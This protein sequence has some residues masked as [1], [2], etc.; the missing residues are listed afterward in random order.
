MTIEFGEKRKIH[1]RG[2]LDKLEEEKSQENKAISISKALLDCFQEKWSIATYSS[3]EQQ[4]GNGTW[5]NWRNKLWV[6]GVICH[7]QH[8]DSEGIQSFIKQEFGWATIRDIGICQESAERKINEKFQ[9][10]WKVHV[11][12]TATGFIGSYIYGGWFIMNDIYI[13][14]MKVSA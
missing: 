1:I 14:A 12:K 7:D 3:F 2:V 10:K 11:V 9:G 5:F 8:Y 4:K 13:F 6:Y